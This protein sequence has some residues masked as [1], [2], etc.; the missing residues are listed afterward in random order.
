MPSLV[1][2]LM[3][4]EALRS[5]VRLMGK[6]R[7]AGA[8][9]GAGASGAGAGAGAGSGTSALDVMAGLK[10]EHRLQ[11]EHELK[12]LQFFQQPPGAM[13]RFIRRVLKHSAARIVKTFIG[14][15]TIRSFR[16]V[17]QGTHEKNRAVR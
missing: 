12:K 2:Q 13:V 14:Q 6:G 3:F 15:Y 4:L 11:A 9:A 10:R 17:I 8:G 1:Y 5:C 16:F 7:A